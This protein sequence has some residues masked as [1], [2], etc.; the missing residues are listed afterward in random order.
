MQVMS[1][2]Y[3]S[4]ISHHHENNAD[5]PSAA[6]IKQDE[7]YL[8]GFFRGTAGHH[9]WAHEQELASEYLQGLYTEACKTYVKEHPDEDLDD[10][11]LGIVSHVRSTCFNHLDPAV[12]EKYAV[13]AKDLIQPSGTDP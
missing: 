3:S 9:I 13:K 6:Q 5:G 8:A 1:K 10:A 2:F 7:K 12:R 4:F 11:R